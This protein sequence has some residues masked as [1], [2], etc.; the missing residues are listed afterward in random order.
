[1]AGVSGVGPNQAPLTNNTTTPAANQQTAPQTD[2]AQLQDTFHQSQRGADAG[3]QV[4]TA[5]NQG[6]DATK[7][8]SS[9]KFNKI[10]AENLNLLNQQAQLQQQAAQNGQQPPAPSFPALPYDTAAD[11]FGTMTEELGKD[12][13]MQQVMARAA[14]LQKQTQGG[15]KIPTPV[16]V[17]QALN[18]AIQQDQ[19]KLS[20]PKMAATFVAGNQLLSSYLAAQGGQQGQGAQPGGGI[21]N[22]PGQLDPSGQAGANGSTLPPG[23]AAAP[24][25]SYTDQA[26]RQKAVQD[27]LQQAQ[28]IYM[29]MAADRQKW[30]MRW[31][32]IMQDLQTSIFETIQGVAQRR[33]Q[34]QYKASQAWSQVMNGGGG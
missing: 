22:I 21:P 18:E 12:P 3:E 31:W 23:A 27:D 7:Q 15:E 19:G 10:M 6:A 34:A 9:D 28:T 20:D 1:M 8:G 16:F 5:Q 11:R 14:Q 25:S 33:Q 32:Q 24:T 29:Q 4:G 30:F 26:T 17:A 13:T 2:D